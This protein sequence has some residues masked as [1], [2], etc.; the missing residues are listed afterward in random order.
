MQQD[1]KCRPPD[2]HECIAI[3]NLGGDRNYR[4]GSLHSRCSSFRYPRHLT[5]SLGPCH[6]KL[7][8]RMT[9]RMCADANNLA[10]GRRQNSRDEWISRIYYIRPA[11]A[12][13]CRLGVSRQPTINHYR[14]GPALSMVLPRTLAS[15]SRAE[16]SDAVPM[17]GGARHA[18]S[19][20]R[21]YRRSG[22]VQSTGRATVDWASA[23]GPPGLDF[24][25]EIWGNTATSCVPGPQTPPSRPGMRR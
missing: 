1:R 21:A 14:E 22:L 7:R 23:D 12:V 18:G 9:L 13:A 2:Q 11:H 17:N 15:W 20:Q 8:Q 10:S 19:P 3:G 5:P 16:H 25:Q 6:R 4:R 24:P